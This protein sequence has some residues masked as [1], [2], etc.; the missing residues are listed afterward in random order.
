MANLDVNVATSGRC[1]QLSDGTVPTSATATLV[2]TVLAPISEDGVECTPEST[3]TP[4]KVWGGEVARQLITEGLIR[5]KCTFMGNTPAVRALYHGSSIVGGVL[6]WDAEAVV[7]SAFA[8]QLFDSQ[9]NGE[10]AFELH[11]LPD[12][13]VTAVD[14]LVFNGTTPVQFG[15]EIT[16]HKKDGRH[17][18]I[19]IGDTQVTP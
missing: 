15:V 12:G 17:V 8:F 1:V 2:G 16:A 11:Y 10:T 4:L 5:Y 9:E 13:E 3:R 19:F 14:A 6:K 18:D 7:R